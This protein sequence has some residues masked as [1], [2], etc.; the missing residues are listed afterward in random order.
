VKARWDEASSARNGQVTTH[1]AHLSNRGQIGVL[2]CDAQLEGEA[3]HLHSAA[4]LGVFVRLPQRLARVPSA[5]VTGLAFAPS[6]LN[7]GSTIFSIG[8]EIAVT[9]VTGDTFR[10]EK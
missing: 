3:A 1:N 2:L 4:I 7:V 6:V 5:E 10:N 8:A 9:A